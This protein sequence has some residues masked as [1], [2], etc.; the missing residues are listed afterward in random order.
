MNHVLG[1]FFLSVG[2]KGAEGS[3]VRSE[4]AG[5]NGVDLVSPCFGATTA[6]L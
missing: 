1:G 2:C 4:H 6:F 3:T 5:V